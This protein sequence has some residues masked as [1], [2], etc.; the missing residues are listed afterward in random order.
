[1]KKKIDA[2]TGLSIVLIIINLVLFFLNVV[3]GD[4]CSGEIEV[5]S[6]MP[7]LNFGQLFGGTVYAMPITIVPMSSNLNVVM[8]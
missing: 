3:S 2:M 4:S 7:L 1:M 6:Q 5:I 8:R